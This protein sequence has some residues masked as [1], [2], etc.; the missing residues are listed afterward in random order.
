MSYFKAKMHQ[1]RFRLGFHP[2]PRWRRQH[3]PSPLA[4]FNGAY[5]KGKGERTGGKVKG[6]GEKRGGDLLLRRGGRGGRKGEG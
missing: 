2:R 4:G 6:G 5:F 1:F 3:S